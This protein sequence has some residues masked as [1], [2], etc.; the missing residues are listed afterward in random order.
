MRK[1]E[2]LGLE[3]IF[4]ERLEDALELRGLEPEDLEAD[5]VSAASTIKYYG[6]YGGRLPSLR[7]AV[8]IACHLGVSL[9]WL[10]GL[11]DDMDGEL[12]NETD[13]LL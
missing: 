6:R 10:C 2:D 12:W 5:D 1:K 11:S 4:P 8:R 7:T 9:D 3:R 13:V